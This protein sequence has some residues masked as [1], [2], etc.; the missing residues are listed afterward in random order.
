MAGASDNAPLRRLGA[1][2]VLA[3]NRRALMPALRYAVREVV[4]NRLSQLANTYGSDKGFGYHGYTRVYDLLLG[5]IR[6]EVRAVLEIGLLQHATQR[7]LG[8]SSF[9]DAPS[10]RMLAEYFP[11]ARIVGFDIKDFSGFRHPRCLTVRGDQSSREDLRRVAEILDG[12]LLDVVID[13]GLHAS[14]HQQI[15]LATLLPLVRGGGFYFVEDLHY[16]P[17]KAESPDAVTTL[18]VLQRVT[19]GREFE[20]PALTDEENR[21]T[22]AAIASI[23]LHETLKPG[24]VGQI[25]LAV[26]RKR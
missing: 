20:S 21:R 11:N 3:R 8:G 17:L 12:E 15:S 24:R 9:V 18:E 4:H 10:L 19:C 23:S 2:G 7:R 25:G 5:G 22:Q 16:Q 13:D 1:A 6:H 14:R 26:I